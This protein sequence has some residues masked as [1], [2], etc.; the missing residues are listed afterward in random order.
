MISS[1]QRTW[2]IWRRGS[3]WRGYANNGEPFVS[4]LSFREAP[5]PVLAVA[6]LSGGAGASVLAYLIAATAARESSAPVLVV[7]TGG[8]TGGLASYAGVSAPLTLADIAERLAA[9]EPV[10][11]PLWA[12]GKHGLR[13]LAGVPQFT[14]DGRGPEI[15]R[16]LSDAREAHGLTV[17]DT[18]TLARRAEQ[19]ALAAATHIAW[20]L[21]A[22]DDGVARARRVLERIAPL[23]R[24]EL[25]VARA[26]PAGRKPA[27]SALADLAD[28]RRAPLVLMP[29]FGEL[30]HAADDAMAEQAGLALQAIGGVLG[31]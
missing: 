7:D 16:V 17:A 18:G 23:S 5:G 11:G 27:V 29:T 8:P 25:L 10:G 31:R 1:E 14:V 12:E 9:G 2:R 21:V 26:D 6:G 3:R 22:N 28:D 15:L 24:P 30:S 13:V 19:A 4:A 20:M